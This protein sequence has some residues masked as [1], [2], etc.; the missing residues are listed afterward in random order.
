MP[1]EASD[2][3]KF[4]E[5]D[6]ITLSDLQTQVEFNSTSA[7]FLIKEVRTYTEP[8]G[9]FTYTGY[10]AAYKPGDEIDEQKGIMLLV[11]DFKDIGYDLRV[12]YL[13]QDGPVGDYEVILERKPCVSESDE[14]PDEEDIPEITV[15]LSDRFDNVL[16]LDNEEFHVTWDKQGVTFFGVETRSTSMK[17]DQKTIAEYF[18][19]DET[20]GN[21]HCFIEWTGDEI[22]GW[23]EIWYGCDIRTEDVEMYPASM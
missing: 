8:S 22:E 21:P 4:K 16:Y 15:D 5:G 11:R 2:F 19:D 7:D 1:K 10:L 13:D 6:I 20:K 14:E 3:L 23:I 9:S 18:T 12:Y 17:N